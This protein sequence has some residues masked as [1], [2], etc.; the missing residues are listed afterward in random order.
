MSEKS[1]SSPET[2]NSVVSGAPEL[3]EISRRLLGHAIDYGPRVVREVI[4]AAELYRE[5]QVQTA[6]EL[7]T[8]V[9]DGLSVLI[10]ASQASTSELDPSDDSDPIE[11][12]KALL[13]PLNE[14]EEAYRK[15]DWIG[16][17]DALEYE[18][19]SIISDWVKDAQGPSTLLVGES[20]A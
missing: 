13:S 14:I 3:E 2:A 7:F 6:N 4:R 19:A 10:Y 8:L 12:S 9:N 5:G 15:N 20:Q 11:L 17:A 16:V 1:L 18:V